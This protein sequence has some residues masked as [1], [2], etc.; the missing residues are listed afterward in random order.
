MC[1]NGKE[2]LVLQVLKPTARLNK[3]RDT[4]EPGD[5]RNEGRLWRIPTPVGVD[6]LRIQNSMY[7]EQGEEEEGKLGRKE[8]VETS[9]R[10][11]GG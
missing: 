10:R 5:R 11:V 9:E 7:E 2:V 6:P 4:E 8:E 1:V 3:D